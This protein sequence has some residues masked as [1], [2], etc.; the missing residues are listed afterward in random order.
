MFPVFAISIQ[1]VASEHFLTSIRHQVWLRLM[2]M[3]LF[4]QA[5]GHKPQHGSNK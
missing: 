1:N 4:L 3:S 5:L 2:G